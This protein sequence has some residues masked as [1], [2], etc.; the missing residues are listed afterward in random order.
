MCNTLFII[1]FYLKIF[2]LQF[3]TV[4]FILFNFVLKILI[5]AIYK[6]KGKEENKKNCMKEVVNQ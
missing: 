1:F 3:Y 2:Y 4:N 5:R 6:R